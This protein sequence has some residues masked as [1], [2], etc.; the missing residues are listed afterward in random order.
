M[1]QKIKDRNLLQSMISNVA[2]F[3]SRV[4]LGGGQQGQEHEGVGDGRGEE[5]REE[6]A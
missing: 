5:M 1:K 2:M 4:R 6:I 3:S